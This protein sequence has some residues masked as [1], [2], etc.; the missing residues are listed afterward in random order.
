MAGVK[1]EVARVRVF[2]RFV[3]RAYDAHAAYSP[4][5]GTAGNGCILNLVQSVRWAWPQ[6]WRIFCRGVNEMRSKKWSLPS[7]SPKFSHVTSRM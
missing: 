6:C 5:E 1:L 3:W 7:V 2:A 4:E